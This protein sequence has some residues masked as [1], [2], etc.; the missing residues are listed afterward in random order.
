[1][2]AIAKQLVL[3]AGIIVLTM[4][5]ATPTRIARAQSQGSDAAADGVTSDPDTKGPPVITSGCYQG[6]VFN[7]AQGTGSITFFFH[8][9]SAGKILKKD[10]TYDIEYTSEGLT[11]SGP[12]SGKAT[13]TQ[14]KWKGPAVGNQGSQCRVA[15][16][17][18]PSGQSSLTGNYIYSGKCREISGPHNPFTGGSMSSLVFTGPTC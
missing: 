3:L 8:L 4:A 11:E 18:H 17:M 14:F 2:G 13:A 6:D 15:G 12:I 9:S 7:D 5:V 1:M 10:S 16:I